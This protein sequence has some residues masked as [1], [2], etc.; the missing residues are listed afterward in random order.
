[1][2]NMNLMF[3]KCSAFTSLYIIVPTS[4]YYKIMLIF[5]TLPTIINCKILAIIVESIGK[6]ME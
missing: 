2:V 5:I 3:S 4:N 6:T 1:M